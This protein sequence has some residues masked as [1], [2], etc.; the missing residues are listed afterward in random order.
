MFAKQKSKRTLLQ[1][2][3]EEKM[4]FIVLCMSQSIR[5]KNILN[6]PRYTSNTLILIKVSYWKKL[7]LKSL[8]RSEGIKKHI[9]IKQSIKSWV[10]V[11][12]YFLEN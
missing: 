5:N 6:I 7:I 4:S 1:S 11:R 8:C 3:Y 10:K 2:C 9:I 12:Q